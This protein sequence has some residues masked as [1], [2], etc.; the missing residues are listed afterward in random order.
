[1]T[2][3][4]PSVVFCIT[5]AGLTLVG[6]AGGSAC[7]TSHDVTKA[8]AAGAPQPA[9]LARPLEHFRDTVY[10]SDFGQRLPADAS[11]G[12]LRVTLPTLVN[13][14]SCQFD[15]PVLAGR[16]G[17]LVY[18]GLVDLTG[19]SFRAGLDLRGLQLSHELLLARSTSAAPVRLSGIR[20]AGLLDASYASFGASLHLDNAQVYSLVAR[21]LSVGDGVN[22][23]RLHVTEGL[24]LI[25]AEL[26]GYVDA[27][28]VRCLGDAFFDHVRNG[29]RVVLDHAEVFGRLSLANAKWAVASLRHVYVRGP[30][31]GLTPE[32]LA[33]ADLEGTPH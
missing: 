17:E 16:P 5:A 25:E 29:D 21:R 14:R 19:A 30:I 15:G 4:F 11:A 23:Q 1:M 26:G 7:T 24:S 33:K 6:G 28:Y 12:P 13:L 10:L 31:E 20:V 27:T 8:T 32:V 3:R 22:L 2:F 18:G 9:L